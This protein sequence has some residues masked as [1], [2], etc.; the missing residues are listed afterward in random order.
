MK[1]VEA[2]H[3]TYIGDSIVGSYVN[4]GAGTKI[5]NLQFRTLEDK[6]K[7][8]FPEIPVFYGNKKMASGL[9]KFGAIVGDGCETGCNSVL[10]PFVILEPECWIMPNFC[11]LKGNYK[12][13]T[14]LR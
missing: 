10:C 9:S 3:F 7:E 1:H 2:G 6:Q 4:F 5:S 14:F 8:H 12:R 13:G 11:V